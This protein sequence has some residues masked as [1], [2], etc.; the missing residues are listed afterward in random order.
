[1]ITIYCEAKCANSRKRKSPTNTENEEDHEE[2]V[3]KAAYKLSELHREKYD[4]V[5]GGG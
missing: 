5:S 2:E 4:Y 1:M 3:S